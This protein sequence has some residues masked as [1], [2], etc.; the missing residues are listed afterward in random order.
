MEVLRLFIRGNPEP[1]P[2]PRARIAGKGR[3]A[4]VHVY[5]AEKYPKEHAKAGEELPWLTWKKRV[6]NAIKSVWRGEPVEGPI[7]MD[8]DFFFER[9]QYLLTA[10]APAGKI[11]HDVRPDGFD[12]C[13]KLVA[14][15]LME[16]GVMKDDG[17]VCQGEVQKWWPRRG[18]PCG[19]WLIVQTLADAQAEPVLFTEPAAEPARPVLA[20]PVRPAPRLDEPAP[21]VLKDFDGLPIR[22]IP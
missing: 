20:K 21:A 14:D 16:C 3:K 10:K 5:N 17:Q 15:A 18:D 11:P 12:N 2:R 1:M 9:P 22:S 19:C 13:A 6:L 8:I 7:R 4:F